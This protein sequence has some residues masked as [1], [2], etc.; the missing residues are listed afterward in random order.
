MI[1]VGKMQDSEPNGSKF[2]CSKL[3]NNPRTPFLIIMTPWVLSKNNC[4]IYTLR[5]RERHEGNRSWF[6]C[7]QWK[8]YSIE[9]IHSLNMHLDENWLHMEPSE[10]S[11][12]KKYKL[13]EI[14]ILWW[15]K[16]VRILPTTLSVIPA[17]SHHSL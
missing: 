3:L 16:I 9:G 15:V 13:Y 14:E 5:A 17:S 8:L 6:Y 7:P 11:R 4:I 10:L 2:E 1:R 12:L